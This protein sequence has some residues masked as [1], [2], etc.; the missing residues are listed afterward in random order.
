MNK[1]LKRTIT[2]FLPVEEGRTGSCNNCGACCHLPYRC[3][4]LKT[5][6]DEKEYC[7]IY[8]VRP[9]NCRKFPR[10]AEEHQ[11][12]QDT[13]GFEFNSSNE[14][15]KNGSIGSIAGINIISEDKN[16]K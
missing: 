6:E 8:T 11:L 14:S 4:F 2:S 12:V 9:P 5:A 15:N 3:V 1:K 16:K 13:C 7:S 10:T